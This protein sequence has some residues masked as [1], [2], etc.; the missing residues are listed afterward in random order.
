MPGRRAYLKTSA[1]VATIGLAGCI[2][3]DNGNGGGGGSNGERKLTSASILP[4]GHPLA[5]AGVTFREK[6]TEKTDGKI[7]WEHYPAGQLAGDPSGYINLV[8][9]GSADLVT[10]ATAYIEGDSPLATAADLPGTYIDTKVG[11]QA[12]WLYAQDFLQEQTWDDLGLQIVSCGKTGPYQLI[13]AG[14]QINTVEKWNGKTIRVASGTLALVVEEMGGSPTEMSSGDVYS[15][16]QRG[17]ID[18]ALNGLYTIESYDW[19][20]VADY[21]TTNVNLG[22]GGTLLGLDK[23]TYEG[24]DDDVKEAMAEAS[25]ES[26]QASAENII[27]EDK[28]AMD[29]DIEF[30]ELPD[31]EV[32]R[33][34]SKVDPVIQNWIQRQEEDGHAGSEAFEAWQS[35]V[36]QARQE[37]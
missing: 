37:Q 26:V 23:K 6:V 24:F 5:N 18:G 14:D 11:A 19:G 2:G 21:S 33:W 3:G 10:V 36:E 15:A 8:Q 31:D 32:E 16:M 34:H 20:D 22:S 35:K 4:E 28:A 7:Q 9:E 12:L 1:T 29:A 27:E 13:H 17:T 25:E 30:F